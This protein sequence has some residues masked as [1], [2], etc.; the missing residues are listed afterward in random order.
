MISERSG[1][2][3]T[4]PNRSRPIDQQSPP[5]K[6]SVDFTDAGRRDQ[7]AAAA[8][9]Q[10]AESQ[11]F[12]RVIVRRW[13]LEFADRERGGGGASGFSPWPAAPLLADGG[14][15]TSGMAAFSAH[16]VLF[17]AGWQG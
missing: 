10:V 1:L 3:W 7:Q 6:P 5:C 11:Q 16:G 9:A 14:D 4:M 15:G 17:M 13:R 12:V 2:A 8:P